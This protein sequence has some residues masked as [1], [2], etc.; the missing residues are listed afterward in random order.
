MRL[1]APLVQFDKL[2]HQGETDAKP[3]LR[4]VGTVLGSHEQLKHLWQR[5][6]G[7]THAIITHAKNNVVGLDS[8]LDLDQALGRG[9]FHC[10]VDQIHRDLRQANRIG[11]HPERRACN[12]RRDA[13][14]LFVDQ[15]LT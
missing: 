12:L 13:M 5:V 8:R 14:R 2:A 11:E 6:G 15:R 10:V 1:D 7:E 9:V 3:A 4:R